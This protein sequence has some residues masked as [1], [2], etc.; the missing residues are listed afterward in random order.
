MVHTQHLW[1]R[2]EKLDSCPVG[3]FLIVPAL[4]NGFFD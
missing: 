4:K 3:K 1:V 2:I